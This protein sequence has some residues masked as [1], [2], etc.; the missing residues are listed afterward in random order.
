M[1]KSG[2]LTSGPLVEELE[3]EFRR[4]AGTKYAAA[5]NSGTAALHVLTAYLH[6]RP[7]EQVIVPANTFAA[8]ANA[9]VFGG[10]RPVLADCNPE[11][12]NVTAETIESKLSPNTRAVFVTHVG[13][14]PCELD[15]IDKL[16]KERGL[17]LLEDAAH[18]AGAKYR[19]RRCGS[20]SKG[21]AFSLY[22][23][24]V[25]TSGEGGFVCTSERPLHEF[26]RLFRNAGRKRY[27]SGPILILGHNYRMSDI[28]AAIGLSQLGHIDDFVKKRQHLARIYDEEV[29]RLDWVR[30]QF[31]ASHSLSSYYA[32]IV[33]LEPRAPITRKKL[34]SRLLRNG[35][36]TTVMF[37]P[38][39]RQ[40][41]FKKFIG[42]RVSLPNAEMIGEQSLVLPLHTSMTDSDVKFVAREIRAAASR[43]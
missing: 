30:P 43:A 8:T 38:V 40:P 28:H 5:V 16:C 21:S 25:V 36:E 27:G 1:L 3:V 26:A 37:I 14:N 12:F 32:Y 9:V 41:Y 23:T 4:V 39:H 2:W 31:V 22:S 19:G 15:E 35:I 10:G 6:L 24:K 29:A 33:V 34:M 18:A 13:G 42:E 11:S 7:K 17:V 20:F